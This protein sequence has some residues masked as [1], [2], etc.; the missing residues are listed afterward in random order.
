[1]L[2]VVPGKGV[3]IPCGYNP[4]FLGSI[5]NSDTQVGGE[6]VAVLSG[7]I[8]FGNLTRLEEFGEGEELLLANLWEKYK[9]KIPVDSCLYVVVTNALNGTIYVCGHNNRGEWT[10]FA[11]TAGYA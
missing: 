10:V 7:D 1:M 8:M 5:V 2:D 4:L 9:E 11:K 3:G 6:T